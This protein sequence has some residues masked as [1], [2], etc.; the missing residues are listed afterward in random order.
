[1]GSFRKSEAANSISGG[2]VMALSDWDEGGGRMAIR[3]DELVCSFRVGGGG[4]V[5]AGTSSGVLLLRLCMRLRISLSLD[6]SG[7]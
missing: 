6:C 2:S 5:T 3:T 1:M 4:E 7:G